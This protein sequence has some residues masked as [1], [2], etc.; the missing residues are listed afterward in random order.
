MELRPHDRAAPDAA[1]APGDPQG[2]AAPQMRLA[3]EGGRLAVW[4]LDAATGLVAGLAS[5]L[6]FFARAQVNS[7]THEASFRLCGKLWLTTA[8]LS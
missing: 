4:D 6:G 5:P 1:S 8:S 2:A 3:I 7:L